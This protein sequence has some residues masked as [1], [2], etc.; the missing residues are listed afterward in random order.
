MHQIATGMRRLQANDI[1]HRD[2]KA[3]NVL[4]NKGYGKGI[5]EENFDSMQLLCY[6]ADFESCE[7]VM[8]TGFWRAPEV[9]LA[10]KSKGIDKFSDGRIWTKKVDVYRYAMTCYEVLTGCIPFQN[11]AAND[12]D[13][14]IEGERPPLPDY[15]DHEMQNLLER[16]WHC[17][18]SIRPTFDKISSEE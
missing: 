3:A 9:L 1:L 2:L 18:P 14:I 4:V 17:V 12:Y 7:G 13:S 5:E 8:G 11:R 6:V 15:V 10:L 16:C